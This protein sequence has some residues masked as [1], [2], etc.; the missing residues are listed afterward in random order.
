MVDLLKQT[1]AL[2][3][4]WEVMTYERTALRLLKTYLKPRALTSESGCK[5][6]TAGRYGLA[7]RMLGGY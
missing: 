2:T 5:I 7:E 3:S 6:N 1:A 4:L